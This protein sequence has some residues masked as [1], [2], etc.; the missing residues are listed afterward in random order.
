MDKRAFHSVV[1]AQ[2]FIAPFS[3]ELHLEL[4]LHYKIVRM[5]SDSVKTHML[6]GTLCGWPR[7]P[8]ITGYF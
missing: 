8:L 5:D 1:S 4:S 3:F 2:F 7:R 6:S